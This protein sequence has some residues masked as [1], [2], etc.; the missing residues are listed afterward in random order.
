MV[1]SGYKRRDRNAKGARA[2]GMVVAC[3]L[4]A[5]AIFPPLS[6]SRSFVYVANDFSEN[7]SAY[8]VASN[9]GLSPVKGS[10]FSS[11]GWAPLGVALSPDG[12]DLYVTDSESEGVSAYSIAADGSLSSVPGSPFATGHGPWGV[13]LRPDGANLYVANEGANSVSAY[14][15]AADGSLNPVAGSPFST[16][17]ALTRMGSN[18]VAVSPD[19]KHLYVSNQIASSV[20]AFSIAADGSLNPVAG[21]P[22]ATGANPRAVSVSPDGQYLYL[23][24]QISED[25]SAYSIAADGSLSPVMGSPFAIEGLPLGVAVSADG[26]HLY[27]AHVAFGNDVWGYSIAADGSLSPVTGSPFATGGIRGNS[28]AVSPDSS[29]LYT[30]NS[31]SKNVS[32]FSISVNG[33]LNSIAGSPFA[34][35]SGPL[36]IAVSPDQGPA[37]AFSMTP[38][39]TGDPSSFDASASSDPDGEVAAYRWDFG[40]G[41]TQ[42]TPSSTVA[43]IYTDPGEYTVTL[44]VTDDAG[45]ST[46]RTF[47]G[48]TV[49]CNGSPL[50]RLSHRATIP[51]GV[52][53][54]ASLTGSGSGSVSSSP[55]GIA[56]PDACSYAYVSGTRL[57]LAATPAANSTFGGWSGGGCAG[58]GPC[59]VTLNADTDLIATFN[60][61]LPSPPRALTVGLTGG[62]KGSVDDSTDAISCPSACSH[63][64]D[65]GTEVT[66]T[67]TP[68]SGSIFAGWSESGCA[69]ERTC[70]VTVGSDTTLSASFTKA[71]PAA[72]RL[73]IGKA[74]EKTVH[75]GLRIA[76]HGTIAAGARGAVRI[77]ARIRVGGRWVTVSR[78][79]RIAA[80][81]WRGQLPLAPAPDPDSL[82]HFSATFGG[83][84]G[85]RLGW[86]ELRLWPR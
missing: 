65:N 50:A 70:R 22:F 56:C 85:F 57:M 25:I 80:G 41:Q 10:P 53:L 74:K 35:G 66:L 81:G 55:L 79:A 75:S 64:F 30:T 15:V 8:S 58:T 7:I 23:V 69:S 54:S 44:T 31:T 47:T 68:A 5:L 76:V 9:G 63:S 51:V 49:S 16:G 61:V 28:V 34:T 18:G 71:P 45:C 77:Q 6:W 60:K 2:G 21:S 43:H 29:H 36:Q 1:G 37:A 13:A 33:S 38:K 62:G 27:V 72:P 39:P 19:G 42:V 12:K 59:Q 83:S 78:R 67:A 40:D 17:S 48:Q 14:S 73:R 52:S 24:N 20:S 82:I 84:P 86:D 46:T 26:R 4:T 11:D 32:A 3:F